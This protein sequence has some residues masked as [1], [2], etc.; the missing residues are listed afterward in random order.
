[1]EKA[2]AKLY[3][4]YN[5]IVIGY[6]SD[7][8][9]DLTG[10]PT[11]YIDIKKQDIAVFW[12][13]MEE[14]IAKKFVLTVSSKTD[15]EDITS[16]HCYSIMNINEK[17]NKKYIKIRNP[18][19]HTFALSKNSSDTKI[20]NEDMLQPNGISWMSIDDFLHNF[21]VVTSCR[22]HDLYFYSYCI[23]K[24]KFFYTTVQEGTHCYF[25]VHQKHER[26]FP[27]T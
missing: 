6:S 27:K 16:K 2:Y 3:N 18:Q 10:A 17:N 8:L 21:E 7:A 1:L 14:S 11:E 13:K 15:A 24:V 25:S 26:F 4:G 20:D 19:G 9:R 23:S 5:N 12:A 22:L